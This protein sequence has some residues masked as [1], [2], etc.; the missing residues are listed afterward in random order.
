MWGAVLYAG[1][2]VQYML[3]AVFGPEGDRTTFVFGYD[4]FEAGFLRQTAGT[5]GLSTRWDVRRRGFG[6]GEWKEVEV[7]TYVLRSA[8][9]ACRDGC[10]GF[11]TRYGGELI[12]RMRSRRNGTLSAWLFLI[13]LWLF[14]LALE[15][16]HIIC[17]AQ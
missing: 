2:G 3:F 17:N 12:L 16:I 5:D 1:G 13:S 15:K 8:G 9:W 14:F 6:G 4:A 11:G 7:G 10:P